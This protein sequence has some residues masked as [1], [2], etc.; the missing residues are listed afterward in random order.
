MLNYTL[1]YLV[2]AYQI[3]TI[4]QI[5][6]FI[7]FFL[8]LIAYL[9][10]KDKN[11]QIIHGI[12]LAFWSLHFYSIW[13][14]EW[15][16]V[17]AIWSVRGFASVK[18]KWNNKVLIFF[19]ILYIPSIILTYKNILSFIPFTWA[20]L[21]TIAFF[22]FSW[23]KMRLLLIFCSSLWLVY[24]FIWHS[25]WWLIVNIFLIFANSITIIRLI[26]EKYDKQCT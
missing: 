10:K 26:F 9:N 22:K 21:N 4:G 5:I 18:Y 23:I 16:V 3:N 15:S 17:N 19:L 7:W 11:T 2:N 8:S 25:I 14:L 1:D 12:S 6:G 24:N 20:T 13:L